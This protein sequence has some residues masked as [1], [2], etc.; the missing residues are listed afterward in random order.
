MIP[1]LTD[2]VRLRLARRDSAAVTPAMVAEAVR[3]CAGGVVG[4]ND[5][6]T[7]LTELRREF[8]GAGPLDPLLSTPD[9]TDILVT[10][11]D[12]V[13]TDGP[14]GLRRS[15]TRFPDDDAVRRLAQR[16]ALSA[17]RRLDDAQPFVDA[18]LPESVTPV[19]VRLHA[20]LPPVATTTYLSLRVLRPATHSLPELVRRGTFCP[21]TA[22]LL[23]RIVQA[24]LAFLVSGSTGSGKTT[25]LSA[26]LSAVPA[27]ERIICIED[28]GELHPKHP[29]F[30]RL[31]SRPPNIEGAG[32]ITQRDLVRQ[33][34]R[35]RPDRIVVGEVRGPE[36]VDLLTALNTGHEGGAGTVHANTPTDVPARLEAL[37][38]LTSL[39]REAL[40]TQL[41]AA[42]H[43]VLHMTRT[44]PQRHLTEIAVLHRPTTTVQATPVWQNGHPTAHYP[45]LDRL[46]TR[47]TN[48]VSSHRHP[49]PGWH[50]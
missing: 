5:M 40:H 31:L 47:P 8:I 16:L 33:S 41:A 25:L 20:V 15:D 4:Q 44:G 34:L 45:L 38:A 9:V 10:A 42:I 19:R 37:A 7:A 13:W 36:V 1:D 48:Q 28:A 27:T 35:M 39:P 50:P 46:L 6:N 3:E 32:E 43:L 11:P 29:Q 17:G 22:D 49:H 12:E 26:L 21:T 18:W 24:R 30:V 2:R 14:Q 23:T